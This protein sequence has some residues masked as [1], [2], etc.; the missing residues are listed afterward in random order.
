MSF[1]DRFFRIPRSAF[2]DAV[3]VALRPEGFATGIPADAVVRPEGFA[4]G[5]PADAVASG[6][7]ASCLPG[8]A[9]AVSSY[10]MAWA[11]RAPFAF[12][13]RLISRDRDGEF[14]HPDLFPFVQGADTDEA[15]V[16]S[17]SVLGYVARWVDGDETAFPD[18]VASTGG[19][20][21]WEALRAW[22]PK[23]PEDGD[24]WKLAA[25]TDTENGPK[26]LFVRYVDGG[27]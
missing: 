6:D 17:L 14:W 19:D 15:M 24:G 26:A 12:S 8:D 22:Q 21:Y 7:H 18:D 25:I 23:Q 9:V 27:R 11:P 5:L 20:R 13:P 1:F 2:R 3:P 4:T 10:A 16:R